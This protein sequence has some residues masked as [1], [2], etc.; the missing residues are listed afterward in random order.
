MLL[1]SCLVDVPAFKNIKLFLSLNAT[2][3]G[4]PF[5]VFVIVFKIISLTGRHTSNCFQV[6]SLAG[7]F[8][9]SYFVTELLFN[10]IS[11]ADHLAPSCY[12]VDLFPWLI[13]TLVQMNFHRM[14]K[15]C[16]RGRLS[17]SSIKWFRSLIARLRVVLSSIQ[18]ILATFQMVLQLDQ[19]YSS[20]RVES[21]FV[22]GMQSSFLRCVKISLV[23][24]F[25]GIRITTDWN[26]ISCLCYNIEQY[27]TS[28]HVVYK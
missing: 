11:V 26:S 24:A 28:L 19:N 1:L 25:S 12:F 5:N 20:R 14:V 22:A 6:I 9:A 17:Y 10:I 18:N 16:F 4:W 21:N 27:D 3:K 13:A 7:R 23:D 8:A 15:N 2:L